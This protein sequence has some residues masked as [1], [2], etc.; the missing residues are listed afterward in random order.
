[1]SA[2]DKTLQERLQIRQCAVHRFFGP[3]ATGDT[4]ECVRRIVLGS[5]GILIVLDEP[6]NAVEVIA[7]PLPCHQDRDV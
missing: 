4:F 3:A 5:N 2:V 6:M 7:T 1:M